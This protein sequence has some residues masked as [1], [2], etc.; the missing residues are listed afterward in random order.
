MKTAKINTLKAWVLIWASQFIAIATFSQCLMQSISLKNRI[1]KAS[2]AIIGTVTGAN[3]Y[4]DG[5]GNIYTRSTIAIKVWAKNYV[6]QNTL[7]VITPGG[8]VGNEAQITT[9]STQLEKNKEYFLLLD[10]DNPP[11]ADKNFKIDFPDHIQAFIYADAQGAMEQQDGYYIDFSDGMKRT[12]AILL[13]AVFTITNEP[14]RTPEGTIYKAPTIQKHVARNTAVTSF[15]PNPTFSGTITPSNFLKIKGSGFGASPGKVEFKSADNGGST[16]VGV[17]DDET[18]Y[19]YWADDS[20][21]VK[22]PTKA[23]SGIIRINGSMVSSTSLTINYAHLSI[24]STFSGFADT[25][26]QRYY[27]R[28][29]NGD[30]GYTFMYNTTSGFSDSADAK[31]AFERSLT[32]WSCATGINWK[33]SGTTPLGFAKDDV[34][35]VLFDSTLPAGVLGR[36]TSRYTA[37]ATSLCKIDSTIWYLAEVDIQFTDSTS[38]GT[39]WYFGAGSPLASQYDFESV[40]LHELGHAHGLGHSNFSS[41]VMYYSLPDATS[42]RTLS[43]HEIDAGIAKMDYSTPPTC[44]N[45]AGSG[46]PMLLYT[47]GGCPVLP[48]KLINFL[49]EVR[50]ESAVLNW[51]V[52]NEKNID[53]FIIERKTEGH[54]F[55]TIGN[56]L[57]KTVPTSFDSYSF[58]DPDYLA[59]TNFYRLKIVYKD[60]SSEY[61]KILSL[62][63]AKKYTGIRLYPNPATQQLF[64]LSTSKT[65]IEIVSITGVILKKLL[66]YPGKN[67]VD[68]TRFPSGLYYVVERSHRQTIKVVVF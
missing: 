59:A 26:L 63:P 58:T 60:F 33:A 13:E 5:N 20:I 12:E 1:T 36:A 7:Q 4:K 52:E 16:Y 39:S 29:I 23:G 22:V 25:T 56:V 38:T 62:T 68:L 43:L 46:T 34:N 41:E 45:P 3:S 27:L 66:V 15:L 19:P 14:A 17:I 64:I 42:K 28:N 37:S 31:A 9:P 8:M 30:G 57:K 51:Q 35:A 53:Q 18:D 21:V 54:P 32:T 2:F 44:F 47:G 49:G 24:H 10:K 6:A 48:L 61:S 67:S 40:S 55:K 11:Q 65:E 50:N